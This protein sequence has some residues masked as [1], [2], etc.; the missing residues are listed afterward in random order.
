L[1]FYS[2]KQLDKMDCG[3]T[4]LKMVARYYGQNFSIQKLR[5]LS[6]IGKSGVSLLG[7]A[8]AAEKIGFRTTGVEL[9]LTQLK[10]VNLPIILHWDKN[11]FVVL[12]QIKNGKFLIADPAIGL[13]KYDSKEFCEYFFSSKNSTN[14]KGVALLLE[15]S[16]TFGKEAEDKK[17]V[18]LGQFISYVLRYKKLL[19]QL[20]FGLLIGSIL[21]LILPF[22][23]QSIVDVGITTQNIDFIYLVLVAQFML[24]LGRTSVDFLRSWI[25][26]HISTRLNVSI[27]SGFLSKLMQLPISF[28]DTKQMGDIM[29]RMSDQKRIENFLT[30]QYLTTFFSIFNLIVF[31]VVIALYNGTVFIVFLIGSLLYTL[32]ITAFLRRRKELDYKR[33]SISS[34]NQSSIIQ[35]INGMQEI[36]LNG[37]EQQKRW[38]W[39]RIQ[40]KL[41]QYNIKGLALGQYQQA[42]AFIINESK[43]ILIIFLVAKSVVEGNMTLGAMMA[44][45]YILGQLNGPVDQLLSFIQTSQDAR[46]SMERLNEIYEIESEEPVEQSF[47]GT[48]PDN[49]SIQLQNVSYKY[50]GAGNELVL[51][52]IQLTIP[53]GKTTAIVG[54][55]GSGKTTILKLLL[56]FY[57][58]N[59]GEIKVGDSSLHNIRSSI[60]RRHCGT[61]MQDGFIFSDTIARNISVA[62]EHP[63]M[64]LLWKA[65]RV[66]NLQDFV[67]ALPLGIHT[68]IGAEGNGISQGQKQRI[69]I[70]RA[71]YKDPDFIFF[72][73]ATN[74][75]DANNES[76]IM[77]NLDQFFKERTVV[78]VAHRMSTV[79][80]A[81]Q[82]VV[83]HKGEI[84][85]SGDHDGLVALEG[86]YFQ[87]VKN[88]LELGV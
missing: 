84:I 49:K 68:M 46:L 14:S 82:I 78:V 3:P 43:N 26:L 21:Q 39:E 10:E 47:Q 40:A 24:L 71:V 80:N 2:F 45:Q 12:Y 63:D 36:K 48:I 73:E 32:W 19:L 29:Q 35:L 34:Q 52:N 17:K 5:E 38:E 33:F 18:Q 88:Q 42:G 86:E 16:P 74:A 61:V 62:D 72:D 1:K 25:I 53:A 9:S 54:M 58:L 23:T 50:P 70:A 79:R 13:I 77:E 20:V 41:F 81:D 56:G 4:C 8:N 69:L 55:S 60:W 37:C 65:I 22:L 51:R 44:I 87:L 83:L 7:I 11:H 85:E 27:L 67:L 15:P 31:S 66:A 30:N 28:F 57:K 59:Q 64:Q 6:E 76:V 75:L